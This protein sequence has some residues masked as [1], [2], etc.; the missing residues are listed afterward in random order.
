MYNHL[1]INER[2]KA[3]VSMETGTAETAFP[4]GND[5]APQADVALNRSVIEPLV[6]KAFSYRTLLF[7]L[8]FSPAYFMM[9][10]KM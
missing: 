2:K 5:A 9:L 3:P 7:R 8:S 4:I 1:A 10:K 6:K